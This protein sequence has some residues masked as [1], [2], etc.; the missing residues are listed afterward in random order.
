MDAGEIFGATLLAIAAL[1]CIIVI[2]FTLAMNTRK[3]I[4]KTFKKTNN[5]EAPLA[6]PYSEQ[7]EVGRA[8]LGN[9]SEPHA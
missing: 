3:F 6:V 8:A 4:D 5:N 9:T 2:S 7:S 1:G